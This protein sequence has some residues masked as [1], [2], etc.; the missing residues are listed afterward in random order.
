MLSPGPHDCPKITNLECLLRPLRDKLAFGIS[1]KS[2]KVKTIN[3]SY[4]GCFTIRLFLKHPT[5][6]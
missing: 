1:T 2:L 5:V 6:C 4:T 3:I